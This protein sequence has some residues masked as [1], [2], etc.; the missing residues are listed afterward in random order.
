MEATEGNGLLAVFFD[1]DGTLVEDVPY[2]GDPAAVVAMP[3]A[4]QALAA[5]R[6]HGLLVGVV[7]NQSG[8]GRGLISTEQ[9]LAVNARVEE[10]LGPFDV[11]CFCPHVAED[12]CDCRKPAPGLVLEAAALLGIPAS[13]AAVVGDI[14][15]D[16]D[17]AAA[18]GARG[19]LV[20]T[21]VTLEDEVRRAPATAPNLAEAVG[22][23]LEGP[24]AVAVA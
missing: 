23:L 18:A 6:E 15:A 20:P 24:R 8:V 12:G 5:V 2:N 9:V 17:A 14:G 13:R 3:G 7:S 22:L 10:L 1:R 19:V 21:P 16:M 11:W 4:A